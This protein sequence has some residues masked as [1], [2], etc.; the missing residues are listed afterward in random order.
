MTCR[1]CG[2]DPV[3]YLKDINA[4]V[5][6]VKRR[7]DERKS[8]PMSLMAEPLRLPKQKKHAVEKESLREEAIRRSIEKRNLLMTVDGKSKKQTPLGQIISKQL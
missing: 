3:L 6:K 2:F 7:L 8:D 1:H 5:S 4:A